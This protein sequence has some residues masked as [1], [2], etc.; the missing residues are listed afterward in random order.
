MRIFP[1]MTAMRRLRWAIGLRMARSRSIPGPLGWR[2]TAGYLVGY[3]LEGYPAVLEPV[4]V[5]YRLSQVA[6]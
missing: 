6:H 4:L 2:A 1:G 3:Q 5:A